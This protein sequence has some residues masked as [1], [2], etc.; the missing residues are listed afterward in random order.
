MRN[1]FLL[2]MIFT[3]AALISSC[4]GFRD[5]KYG[6]SYKDVEIKLTKESDRCGSLKEFIP[7]TEIEGL[8]EYYPAHNKKYFC[9]PGYVVGDTKKPTILFF[10][11]GAL[12]GVMVLLEKYEEKL[13]ETYKGVLT[14]KYESFTTITTEDIKIIKS[15]SGKNASRIEQIAKFDEGSV[16][17]G[18]IKVNGQVEKRMFLSYTD[19]ERKQTELKTVTTSEL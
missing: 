6:T 7:A 12:S 2:I 19:S 14:S 18:V 10:F 5:L 13:Y 17:L 4:A 11:D 8:E 9:E 15:N 3:T 1:L 16:I